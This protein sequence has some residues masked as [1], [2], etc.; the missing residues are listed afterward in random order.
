ME[1]ID[2]N[3]HSPTPLSDPKERNEDNA[4]L[5]YTPVDGMVRVGWY[6]EGRRYNP[7]PRFITTN[8]RTAYQGLT[9]RVTHWMYV[10]KPPQ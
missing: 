10:P 9:A 8:A 5:L 2:A 4:L 6:I 3:V 7:R 1:W